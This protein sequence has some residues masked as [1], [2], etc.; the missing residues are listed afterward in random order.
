MPGELAALVS[1]LDDDSPTVLAAVTQRLRELADEAAP[2]LRDLA[3]QGSPK[4]RGRAREVLANLE[5]REGFSRLARL[6]ETPGPDLEEGAMLL[7]SIHDPAVDP[8]ALRLKLD[9][10]AEGA[11]RTIGD[12]PQGRPR[13]ERFLKSLHQQEGF[14]GDEEA[15]YAFQN[16]FLDSVLERRRGIPITLILVYMLVGRRIGV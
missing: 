9:R 2:A 12:A 4:V 6:A 16:N 1:L 8:F 10:L 5:R 14:Q 15:F 7:A 3:E 13:I 11:A